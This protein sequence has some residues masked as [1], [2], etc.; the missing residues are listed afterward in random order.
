M[1]QSSTAPAAEQTHSLQPEQWHEAMAWGAGPEARCHSVRFDLLMPDGAIE[2]RGDLVIVI[3]R[4][5]DEIRT[6]A[7]SLLGNCRMETNAKGKVSFL[8]H[9]I[10]GE[11][12]TFPASIDRAALLRRLQTEMIDR[13]RQAIDALPI[14]HEHGGRKT[15]PQSHVEKVLADQSKK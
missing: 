10:A 13:C 2:Q 1:F 7:Y 9:L 6:L 3:S 5:L 4:E 15:Y 12:R 14:L 11:R 8:N